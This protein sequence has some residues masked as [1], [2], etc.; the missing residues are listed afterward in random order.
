MLKGGTELTIPVL[1]QVCF[2]M[3]SYHVHHVAGSMHGDA[4]FGRRHLP[5]VSGNDIL[6]PVN[7]FLPV[8]VLYGNYNTVT[9][10]F[11][12]NNTVVE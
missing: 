4:E 7:H 11:P 1:R 10:V 5:A 8:R 6:S 3:G 2:E 12:I 9:F